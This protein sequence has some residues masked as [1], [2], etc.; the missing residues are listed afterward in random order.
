MMCVNVDNTWQ[1]LANDLTVDYK[2]NII[3]SACDAGSLK[4]VVDKCDK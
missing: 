2:T 4:T 1:H 3:F